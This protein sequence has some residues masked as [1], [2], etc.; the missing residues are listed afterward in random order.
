MALIKT[1]HTH[2][3]RDPASGVFYYRRYSSQKRKQFYKTTG[4]RF[5]AAKA[6]KLG[7]AAYNKWIGKVSNEQG[8]VYFD[9]YAE[10]FLERRLANGALRTGTKRLAQYEITRLV[11]GLGYL[12][13]EKI[14]AEK[15]E[16]WVKESR[17]TSGRTQFV[18]AKRALTQI[19][20]DA[21]DAGLIARVPRFPNLDTPAAPPQYLARKTIRAILKH[22]PSPSL[23]IMAFIMWKQ[24]A[25]PGE[26]LQYRWDMIR[27]DE[28]E[29]G[30][31][32]IPKSIT[33]TKRSRSIPLNSQVSRILVRLQN[34]SKTA[35]IFP[36]R[37]DPERPYTQYNKAWMTSCKLAKVPY[38]SIYALRDTFVTEKLKKGIS[39]VFI[40]KYVDS[41]PK[42]LAERYAVAEEQAMKKVAG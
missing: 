29:Y 27:W 30:H 39:L 20:R 41:S 12:E 18:G 2:L 25:R 6:Y 36:S 33:K 14:T 7:L 24:G 5:S 37:R 3:F 23:K 11:D 21:Q 22:S 4:E 1:K 26:I 31:L 40:A 10:R 34:V 38:V 28:G 13:I 16:D 19:L 8:E 35:L 9:R 42:M 32:H 17:K 15:Y